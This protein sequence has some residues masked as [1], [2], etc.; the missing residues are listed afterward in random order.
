[1][2]VSKTSDILH[3][4]ET[5]MMGAERQE[6]TKIRG[7]TIQPVDAETQDGRSAQRI[8]T[9]VTA[10]NDRRQPKRPPATMLEMEPKRKRV[11][12]VEYE[13]P[14]RAATPPRG[15]GRSVQE[16]YDPILVIDSSH[17][18]PSVSP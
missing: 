5:L 10:T 18:I 17:P 13:E 4:K 15:P 8:Q 2:W 11:S 12:N 7:P 1:M 14:T 16:D 6:D 9:G 3:S